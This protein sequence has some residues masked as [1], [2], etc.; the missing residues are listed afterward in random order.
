[1]VSLLSVVVAG[2]VAAPARGVEATGPLPLGDDL[3]AHNPL[4]GR[5]ARRLLWVFGIAAVAFRLVLLPL[6]HWWDI[7]TFYNVFIDLAHNVSPYDT[8]GHLTH[9]AQSAGWSDAYEYYAYPPVP[10]YIYWP[11]A[12]LFAWLHPTATYFIPVSGATTL[13]SL[14][15][16]FYALFKLPMWI[17]DFLIAALLA[18][19]SGTVRG[20]RDY[21]LNPYVL[22]VSAAWTFDAVMVVGLVA[23]VYW[24]QRGK[25]WQS[26]AA[27]AFGTMVKFIPAIA[28]PTCLLYMIKRRRPVREMVL[29][30]GAYAV[31]C[32]LFLGPFLRGLLDVLAFHG[33]R[34]GGGMNWQQIWVVWDSLPVLKNLPLHPVEVAVASL[35]T[36]TL[37]ICLLIAY[38][39]A[40]TGNLSLNRM[41]VVTLLAFFLGAKLV[42]EQYALVILPFAFIEARRE[43]GA[44][45]WLYRLLWIVPLLF[46]VMRVPI[47]RFFWPLYRTVFG[48][49]A[50]SIATTGLT[51]FE[52][53]FNPWRR[54]GLAGFSIATLG[55]AFFL[56]C[57]VAF[58]W[59]ARPAAL[60]RSPAAPETPE[61]PSGKGGRMD[62]TSLLARVKR[63]TL[64]DVRKLVVPLILL[65]GLITL[66]VF[67]F[68]TV[69]KT[70]QASDAAANGAM[71]C[72]RGGLQ[73]V[74]RRDDGTDRPGILYNGAPVL[75]Y[76]DWSSTISVN[77]ASEELWNHFHGYSYDTAHCTIYSTTTGTGWQLVAVISL[78][79]DHTVQVAYHFAA[80]P[81]SGPTIDQMELRVLHAAPLWLAPTVKDNTLTGS[82]LPATV[83]KIDRRSPPAAIATLKLNESG[84]DVPNNA[85]ELG[86]Y[87]TLVDETGVNLSWAS[88]AVTA[89]RLTSP[90]ADHLIELGVERITVQPSDAAASGTP[91]GALVAPP[92]PAISG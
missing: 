81:S 45:L 84:N 62:T 10:L 90:D 31:F 82:I 60:R 77:G 1:M 70:A 83:H 68:N 15:L 80:R 14:P 63:T 69:L 67:H 22:V 51:G 88:S 76:A 87:H 41:I 4:V 42:N 19:M 92:T 38:Y 66:A 16:D 78:V 28:V 32:A 79:D 21:L 44:W 25:L 40:Y 17:A 48:D 85:I 37:A 72:A 23:G 49:R 54:A 30:L 34:V 36:P 64:I 73:L 5:R 86:G 91:A 43:R 52:G 13:P 59:P 57:L 11:L 6:N 12:H 18:R 29:F 9:V 46:A 50:L 33:S 2:R 61:A 24:L 8:L 74:F 56:L 20:W 7:T 89:Y 3:P 65:V 35:G 47:D 58:L 27:L 55:V 75:S 53:P 26:G 71:S 39:Y